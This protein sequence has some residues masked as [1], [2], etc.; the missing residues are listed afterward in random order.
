MQSA[1]ADAAACRGRRHPQNLDLT[2]NSLTGTIPSSLGGLTKLNTL[3]LSNN[4][5]VVLS[6]GKSV[7]LKRLG[8]EVGVAL[9]SA[10]AI[11]LAI[12]L[13]TVSR[14]RRRLQ[15]V[16]E[17]VRGTRASIRGTPWLAHA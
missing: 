9:G 4:A 1:A 14:R 16:A 13:C 2:S 12:V 15:K 7:D 3:D 5:A 17:L 8:L 11:V 6:I 10:T